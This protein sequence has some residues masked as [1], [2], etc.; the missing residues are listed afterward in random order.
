MSDKK[1]FLITLFF[2]ILV[3][4]S[5]DVSAQSFTFT[6]KTST[7]LVC[8]GTTGLFTDNIKNIGTTELILTISTSGSASPWSTSFPMGIVL[9]PGQEKTIYTYISPRTT[10]R[11]GTYNIEVIANAN[12]EVQKLSHNV[13]IQQCYQYS[14]NVLDEKNVCPTDVEK[15]D[16]LITNNGMFSQTYS[17][18][19]DGQAASWIKLSEDIINLQAGESK[20]I[21]AYITVPSNALGENRFT[22]IAQPQTSPNVQSATALIHVDPCFDYDL[23]AVKNYVSFC[24]H[25]AEKIPIQ[26]KNKGTLTNNYDLLIDGP[27]WANLDKTRLELLPNQAETV[28]LVLTPGFSVEGDFNLI[29]TSISDKGNI[30][31]IMNF[32]ANVRKCNNVLLDIIQDSDKI[33]NSLTNNYNVVIKNPGEVDKQFELSVAGAAW[34]S[35]DKNLVALKA[36]QETA[37]NL[38]INPGFDTLANTYNINVNALALDE[39]KVSS[40]DSIAITTVTREECYQPKINPKQNQISLGYDSSATIPVI[41]ENTGTLTATYDLEITGTASSFTEIN[42]SVITVNPGK[43]EIVFMYIAPTVQTSNNLYEASISARLSDSTILATETISIEVTESKFE[44]GIIEEIIEQPNLFGRIRLYLINF[45]APKIEE[46]TEVPEEAEELLNETEEVIE[47]AE[48]KFN[49]DVNAKTNQLMNKGDKFIF[50][51]NDEKHTVTLQDASETTIV[52][53]IESTPFYIALDPEDSKEIDINDDKINDLRITFNGFKDGK[54]DINYEKII[55]VSEEVTE[56]PTTEIEETQIQPFKKIN[57]SK[58]G[59]ILVSY[60]NYIAAGIII[61]I[62]IILLAGTS[63]RKKIVDFF[64]EEA[65]EEESIKKNKK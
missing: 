32:V 45:F 14:I 16:V 36:G 34:S 60:R 57:L 65:E 24:E 10:T 17:L 53:V 50:T 20:T 33:C 4:V 12:G 26:I 63:A 7:E 31:K 29:F 47:E 62:I 23:A 52:L 19:V 1:I 22:V 27:V 6:P 44:E 3:S 46:I 2:V 28:N 13:N 21:F 5:I 35:L 49:L 25:T 64:E 43:S 48:E 51:I 11:I 39:S 61:L 38:I 15:Y 55:I 9:L 56:E 37:V 42:P 58:A 8:P 41:I 30:E 40:S 18:K 54:A 59:E